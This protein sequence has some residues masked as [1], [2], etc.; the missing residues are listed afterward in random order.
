MS[1]GA[2]ETKC[3]DT[4]VVQAP[5]KALHWK[6]K[7]CKAQLF[8]DQPIYHSQLDVASCHPTLHNLMCPE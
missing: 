8:V 2:A 1:N 3:A 6:G 4:N 5:A 7:G